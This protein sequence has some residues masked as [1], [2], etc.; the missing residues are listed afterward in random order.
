MLH[1]SNPITGLSPRP[2]QARQSPAWWKSGGAA[3]CGQCQGIV[4]D[5]I[6]STSLTEDDYSPVNL[7]NWIL[8]S[9]PIRSTFAEVQPGQPAL[10]SSVGI[11][12]EYY[13]CYWKSKRQQLEINIAGPPPAI[14]FFVS[15]DAGWWMFYGSSDTSNVRAGNDDLTVGGTVFANGFS[16]SWTNLTETGA[17]TLRQPLLE[18]DSR[19][20]MISTGLSAPNDDIS[21]SLRGWCLAL[22][23]RVEIEATEFTP[24]GLVFE[25]IALYQLA[26]PPF[27]CQRSNTWDLTY[28]PIFF[29]QHTVTTKPFLP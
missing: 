15:V 2:E 29:S 21:L 23:N 14:P 10:L 17:G 8:S 6:T 28:N 9:H 18:T 16:S 13:R 25:A 26:S 7:N 22:L 19:V 1:P 20:E 24:E 4:H 27:Q 3:C 11:L 5:Y 12:A